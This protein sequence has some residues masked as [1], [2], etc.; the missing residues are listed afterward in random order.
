MDYVVNYLVENHNYARLRAFATA[1][2]AKD[3][4]ERLGDRLFRRCERAQADGRLRREMYVS[5]A[6][7]YRVTPGR[8][9]PVAEFDGHERAPGEAWH[10]WSDV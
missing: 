6:T 5:L 3:Y 2:A 10:G 7:L 8:L 9:H 1:E 4:V